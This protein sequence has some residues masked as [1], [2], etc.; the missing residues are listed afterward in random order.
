[1]EIGTNTINAVPHVATVGT[2]VAGV[3]GNL[4]LPKG[5]GGEAAVKSEA[6]KTTTQT[7]QEKSGGGLRQEDEQRLE[8]KVNHLNEMMEPF[9]SH[10]KFEI[11]KE[12]GNIM[13]QIIDN[14]ND[15]VI[16]EIPPKKLLDL[17]AA[18]QDVVG[19]F[20]DKRV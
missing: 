11:H 9:N 2:N 5:N 6:E 10:L 20:V 3:N 15:K 7:G 1:M 17:A 16:K 14:R 13:V 8:K 19:L 18:I 12:T 4:Q